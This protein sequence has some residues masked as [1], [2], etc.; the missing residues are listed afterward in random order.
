MKENSTLVL[1]GVRQPISLAID[2]QVAY[3]CRGY[4]VTNGNQTGRP[5]AV[6]G[7]DN[8]LP[9]YK[10]SLGAT[11]IQE[12][13]QRC[14]VSCQEA[15]RPRER[16]P[17]SWKGKEAPP[18]TASGM[19]RTEGDAQRNIRRPRAASRC[20]SPG[21]NRRRI[22]EVNNVLEA[23]SGHHIKEDRS[24]AV[25]LVEGLYLL[26]NGFSQ[27][28]E[29]HLTIAPGLAEGQDVSNRFAQVG[30]VDDYIGTVGS[31]L[32]CHYSLR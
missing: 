24:I 4:R 25:R 15:I 14:S 18:G 22:G 11:S 27:E 29:V 17:G 31:R 10:H 5:G 13:G 21:S 19:T 30:S 12:G 7:Q 32:K 6:T 28:L 1:M 16:A 20:P 23:L 2:S 3:H 8:L 26:G 9:A